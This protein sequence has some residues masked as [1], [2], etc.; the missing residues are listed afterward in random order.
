MGQILPAV[1]KAPTFLQSLGA[2]IGQ[3][4]PGAVQDY[5]QKRDQKES[6]SK[7]NQALTKAGFGDLIGLPEKAQ[8][9]AITERLKGNEKR[10]TKQESADRL[11]ALLDKTQGQGSQLRGEKNEEEMEDEPYK[12]KYSEQF[13]AQL[14][15]DEPAAASQLA[16]KEDVERRESTEKQKMKQKERLETQKQRQPF[17]SEIIN[18]ANASRK[19]IQNKQ[20]MMSIIDQG[21]LDDPSWAV[22]AESLPLNLGQRLLSEDTVTY[23]AA[24]VDEFSDLRNIFQGQTRVK[25][26]EILERKLADVYLTDQQKKAVLKARVNALQTDIIREEAAEFVEKNFPNLTAL[27]FNKKVADETTKRSEALGKLV[28][29]D[30]KNAMSQAETRK[31][32]PLDPSNS[33]D[34]S[35]MQQ[36]LKDSGGNKMKAKEMAKKKGYSWVGM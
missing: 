16:H 27:Q 8:V 26:L 1:Q 24:L 5:V 17:I 20:Q 12:P 28:V 31:K 33:E 30:I 9:A 13:L 3:A 11:S 36:I 19:G 7:Q 23:K 14:A 10:K 18:R 2:G 35:I 34:L 21:N 15:I 29:D 32:I 22:I 4:I 25:E 6:L